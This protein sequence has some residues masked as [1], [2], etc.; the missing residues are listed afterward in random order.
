[1]LQRPGRLRAQCGDG[2]AA[3]VARPR[4]P[5]GVASVH[6]RPA[7]CEGCRPPR[8]HQD[9]LHAG[10]G[11][12]GGRPAGGPAGPAGRGRRRRAEVGC[13]GRIISLARRVS[14][15]SSAGPCA[16]RQR[17]YR[18]HRRQRAA[19]RQT[20]LFSATFPTHVEALARKILTNPVEIVVGGRSVASSDVNPWVE[21]RDYVFCCSY[22]ASAAASSSS[23]TPRHC[24]TLKT[25]L[26]RSVHWY[27]PPCPCLAAR[28]RST[29]L[30]HSLT[31]R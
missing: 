16:T 30:R 29:A 12:D 21:L 15:S 3:A 22:W 1:M 19:D 14:V 28:A 4:P 18:A 25:H 24:N 11:G 26:V 9:E 23:W 17:L 5:R 2:G 27:V 6:R 7:A 8:H 13:A 10:P 31:A 20:H